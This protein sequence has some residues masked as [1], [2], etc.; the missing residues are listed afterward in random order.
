MSEGGQH[1]S[2]ASKPADP[3]VSDVVDL[4]ALEQGALDSSPSLPAL[5]IRGG[6]GASGGSKRER[7]PGSADVIDIDATTEQG[8]LEGTSSQEPPKLLI[9][10]AAAPGVVPHHSRSEQR[11]VTF[12]TISG[13]SCARHS[14]LSPLPIERVVAEPP[15]V[16]DDYDH[17]DSLEMS[18]EGSVMSI[19]GEATARAIDVQEQVLRKATLPV[20]GL[21]LGLTTPRTNRSSHSRWESPH[22]SKS[23]KGFSFGDALNAVRS[24]RSKGTTSW[25][26]PFS[27]SCCGRLRVPFRLAVIL[28]VT[29]GVLIGCVLNETVLLKMMQ[30][31]RTQTIEAHRDSISDQGILIQNL[32]NSAARRAESEILGDISSRMQDSVLHTAD[33][34]VDVLVSSMQNYYDTF[35]SP[36]VGIYP[37]DRTYISRRALLELRNEWDGYS[38]LLDLS[39]EGAKNNQGIRDEPAYP[40][41]LYV[42]FATEEFA[43]A[44]GECSQSGEHGGYK[45][46][47]SWYDKNATSTDLVVRQVSPKTAEPGNIS[48]TLSP[49]VTT[50]RP[51]YALQVDVANEV[52]TAGKSNVQRVWSELYRFSD[53]TM[54]L[55]RTAPIAYC[56]NYSCM[57]GVVAADITLPVVSSACNSA[58]RAFQ[59]RATH[60]FRYDITH[61]NSAVFVVTHVSRRLPAQKGLLIGASTEGAL[62]NTDLT[63]ATNSPSLLVRTTADALLDYF[64]VWDNTSL[65]LAEQGLTFSRQGAEQGN[66]RQCQ[67]DQY[68][69]GNEDCMEVGTLSLA[70]DDDVHWLVVLVSPMATFRGQGSQIAREV[71][72]QVEEMEQEITQVLRTALLFSVATTLCAV[73]VGLVMGICLG[74]SVSRPLTRL[75]ESMKRLGELDFSHHPDDGDTETGLSKIRD[76]RHLQEAF[77]NLSRGIETFARFVPEAVVKRIVRGE[78]SARRLHVERRCVTIMFS[79]IKGFTSISESVDQK[80][81]VFLITCYLSIMTRV[82]ESFDGVV[83]EILGDGLMVLWNCGP[84]D[85]PDHQAKACAAALAMQQAMGP[86][87]SELAPRGMP[88]LSIRIGIHT[89]SVLAGNIGSDRKLKFGCMGDPVNLASRLEGI[90]KYYGC[91]T[92]CS[93][94]TQ[95]ELPQCEGFICRRLDLVQVMGR[96]EPVVIYEVMGKGEAQVDHHDEAATSSHSLAMTETFSGESGASG[97]RVCAIQSIHTIKSPKQ[98]AFAAFRGATQSL[99]DCS[100]LPTA[101]EVS[102][103]RKAKHRVWAPTPKSLRSVMSGPAVVPVSATPQSAAVSSSDPPSHNRAASEQDAAKL[104]KLRLRAER[105]E[106]ALQAYQQAEFAEALAGLEA[107]LAECPSDRAAQLLEKRCLEQLEKRC[108]A[109]GAVLSE[110]ELRAW[111]GVNVMEEKF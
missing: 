18:R 82:I 26:S 81:L 35:Q 41:Y 38:R 16:D 12:K 101:A 65:V 6:S 86:L 109:H 56:G 57:D 8:V 30:N 78:E 60:T 67:Y 61:N 55:T 40:T 103:Q 52:M 74:T 32:T 71:Q 9:N 76:V 88:S 89:G 1:G 104:Q 91:S 33:R 63:N 5:L 107:L 106:D 22:S 108:L 97:R 93:K 94:D 10:G 11:R 48:Q 46:D 27:P 21:A 53:G 100:L 15:A 70:M 85:T 23:L 25:T 84:D 68:S 105:Y 37:A 72:Q 58:W 49:F 96:A 45:C 80:D 7:T 64:R 44:S 77:G 28:A 36:L 79:D 50:A 99:A 24:G 14:T 69:D 31:L 98:E 110:E 29:V 92:I 47:W 73:A 90:C 54:G 39:L 75:S 62:R 13:Q 19:M 111:T 95:Q 3:D 102:S 87:N 59:E 34:A 43:G 66:F 83:T 17:G 4:D 42:G 2:A 51:W 20:P